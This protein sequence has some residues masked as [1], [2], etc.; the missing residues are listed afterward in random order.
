MKASESYY[1]VSRV[2]NG[3]SIRDRLAQDYLCSIISRG[4]GFLWKGNEIHADVINSLDLS[5][6][7]ADL[8]IKKSQKL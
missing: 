8:F 1:P 7:L 2:T 6:K 5:F 3:I 4:T